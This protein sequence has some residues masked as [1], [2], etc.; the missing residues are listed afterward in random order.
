MADLNARQ[1]RVDE[2]MRAEN[3]HDVD[4]IMATFGTDP[5]FELNGVQLPGTSGI[6]GMYDAFGFGNNGSFSD[7]R[8][9]EVHRHVS[10]DAIILE[11][12]INGRHTGEFQGVPASGNAFRIPACAV[13]GFD[14]DEK[15][16][17]ERVYFDGALLMQQLAANNS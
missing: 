12:T 9:D 7:I 8:L 1:A 5:W 3:E 11:L 4:A 6:R 16:A 17:G 15:V 10:D 14:S 2:H 13:F